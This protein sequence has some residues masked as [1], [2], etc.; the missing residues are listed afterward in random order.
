MVTPNIGSANH[1]ETR[2]DHP[3]DYDLFRP[4]QSRTSASASDRTCAS[5]CTS[6]A[7]RW[8]SAVSALLDRCPDLRFDPDAVALDDPHIHG[9]RFRSPTSLPVIWN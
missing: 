2:W 4:V 5:A 7:W 3:D 8:A 6:P 1:D 9:E